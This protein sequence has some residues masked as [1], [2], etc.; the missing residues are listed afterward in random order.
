[1]TTNLTRSRQWQQSREKRGG[2]ATVPVP[3][4]DRAMQP[5]ATSGAGWDWECV[6][7]DTPRKADDME[8]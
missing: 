3:A 2:R 1:M 4:A 7:E 8:P 5:M 6:D